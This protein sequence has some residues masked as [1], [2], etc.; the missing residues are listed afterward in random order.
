[1]DYI[2]IKYFH[3]A[4]IMGL[5]S[6]LVLE[7][8]MIKKQMTKEEIKKYVFVDAVYGIS[9]VLILLT[10]FALWFFVG[11]PAEFYTQNPLIHIKVT[12]FILVALLSIY[13][14]MFF[15]KSRKS[16]SEFVEPPRVI[17]MLVRTSLLLVMILPFLGIMMAQG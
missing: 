7:H 14:T 3:I 10:G 13:P 17:I 8:L 4:S 2:I 9:A 12:I 15:L 16:T 11:K 5:C 6:C 1:M